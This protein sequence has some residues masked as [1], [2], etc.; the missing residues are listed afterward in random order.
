MSKVSAKAPITRYTMSIPRKPMTY[1]AEP[2][3]AAMIAAIIQRCSKRPEMYTVIS[4][5]AKYMASSAAFRKSA[6]TLGPTI[7]SRWMLAGLPAKL[8]SSE[9]RILLRM[10]SLVRFGVEKRTR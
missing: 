4:R 10:P 6:P 8:F 2:R 9:E 1:M 3:T 5:M 7:S